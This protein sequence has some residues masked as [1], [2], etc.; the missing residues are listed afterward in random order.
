MRKTDHNNDINDDEIRVI[1]IDETN[2][3]PR[4]RRP[5]LMVV[6]A[7]VAAVALVVSVMLAVVW[8]KGV[9]NDAIEIE[10]VEVVADTAVE[11]VV[12]VVDVP[13]DTQHYTTVAD[14]VVAGGVPL[15]VMT[16]HSAVPVLEI[17]D[18]VLNDSTAVL[19]VQAADV[20]GDNGGIVGA[21]VLRGDLISRGQSKAGFCAII[22]G[23][24]TV[25]VADATPMLEQAIES[26]GYFFRQYPLVVGGQIVENKP[27]GRALRKALVVSGGKPAVVMSR[28]KLTFH[29]FSQALVDLGVDNAIYLCGSTAYGFARDSAGARY[30]FGRR[31]DKAWDNI[32]YMVWR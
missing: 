4:R 9:D 28:G 10:V 17:G 20:R 11:A 3:V 18:G 29:E 22:N 19:V 25:G 23:E 13:T 2:T 31:A 16:P 6:T 26:E 5:R 12:P 32:N 30:E 15:I 27:R 14:T 21:Y 8:A 7:I 24:A 1:G